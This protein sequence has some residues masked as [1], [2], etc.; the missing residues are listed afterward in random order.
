LRVGLF[1]GERPQLFE[2]QS[3]APRESTQRAFR[4][5]IEIELVDDLT[6]GMD[7]RDELELL[8]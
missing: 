8:S 5:R 3:L 1:G 2:V 4:D 7:A 6:R